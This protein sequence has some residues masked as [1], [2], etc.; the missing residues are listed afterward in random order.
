MAIISHS[1]RQFLRNKLSFT[2]CSIYILFNS[3]EFHKFWMSFDSWNRYTKI[4]QNWAKSQADRPLLGRPAWHLQRH[5][6][7]FE[8]VAM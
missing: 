3:N 2:L 6:P 5:S 8:T 4:E 1:D 7:G